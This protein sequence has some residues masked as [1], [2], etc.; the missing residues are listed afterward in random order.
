MDGAS[1]AGG[2]G[3]GIILKGPEG[4]K[5]CYA[6]RLEFNASN[7]VAEYEVLING[8]L[9]AIEVG[10]TDLKVNI[11]SQLV[12]NQIMGVYQARDPTMQ[13]YL[14]KVRAIEAELKSRGI[15]VRYQR[16]PREKNEEADM[17]SRLTRKELEQLPDEVYI[18]HVNI[19]AFGKANAMM[20]VE[21]GQN[22]M[23]PYL[24]YLER[25]KLPED[26]AEARKIAA[27]V[28]NYQVV[29]GTL[30]RRGKSSP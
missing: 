7:N 22:W 17:L 18:Q 28:A 21:E 30:Y 29:R 19:P 25:G 12:I 20:E 4:F 10:A 1:G 14:A 23:T 15:M 9:V 3:A 8:M 24:E 27:R 6:L 26:K 13:N 5:V 2:S 11:D 16:I